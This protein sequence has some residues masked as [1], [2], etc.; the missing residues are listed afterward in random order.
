MERALYQ[1]KKAYEANEVPVGAILTIDDEIIAE[2]HNQP[3]ASDDPTSHAEINVIRTAAKALSNYRLENSSIY[4]TLEPCLMCCGALIHARI[5]NLVFS[6][7]DPKSGAVI[8]NTRALD[9]DFTNHK[10]QYSQGPFAEESSK[11]LKQFFA[12]KRL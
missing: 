6:A 2:G 5:E 4:V 11:L 8:S 1:A 10:V 7:K 3:I 9:F 12:D